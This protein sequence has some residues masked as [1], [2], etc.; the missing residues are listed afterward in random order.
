MND[1][2]PAAHGLQMAIYARMPAVKRARQAVA[3]SASLRK[4]VWQRVVEAHPG[5]TD[6]QLRRAFAERW[7]GPELASRV[8]GSMEA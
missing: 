3:R 6:I 7:L 1:T 5:A 4:M 8:Y 2:S